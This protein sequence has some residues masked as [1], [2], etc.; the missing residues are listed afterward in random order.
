M[1]NPQTQKKFDEKYTA[2]RKMRAEQ[3]ADKRAAAKQRSISSGTRFDE[4]T[5]ANRDLARQDQAVDADINNILKRFGM[6]AEQRQVAFGVFDD[7]IDLQTALNS[8]AEAERAYRK[9]SPELRQKFPSF[10]TFLDGMET[11]A[12][13]HELEKMGKDH[14]TMHEDS[15]LG[16]ELAREDARA[17]M[18]R[19]KEADAI[20]Q[21]HREGKPQ[22]PAGKPSTKEDGKT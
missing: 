20:A 7:S 12:V 4:P 11:G 9:L 17:Q 1:T 18:R 2:F 21:A 3:L 5:K 22:P 8:T 6:A 19:N 15:A 14:A 16:K 10:Q 13:A